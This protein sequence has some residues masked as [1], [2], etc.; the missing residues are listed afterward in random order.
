MNNRIGIMGGSFDP[1]HIGHLVTAQEALERLDL[2]TVVFLVAGGVHPTK[3]KLAAS[4]AARLEMTRLATASNSRFQVCDWEIRRGK[5][6][7]TIDALR[8]L[9]AT[10]EPDTEF[11][12][13]T[14]ADAVFEILEWKD[15]EEVASLATFIGATRPGYD[16]EH[17]KQ[18]HAA[19]LQ[20]F[21]VRYLEVPALA[22]SST[23]IR[24]RVRT[25]H[26]IRYLTG[27]EVARYIYEHQLYRKSGR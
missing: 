12:F 13:I 17:A 21:D 22:V 7:Y 25:G 19:A 10:C 23:D 18:A 20:Q 26:S 8:H 24:A 1:I 4:P 27:D 3:D 9:R 16:I 15:S 2:S 11:F 14:G 6:T 5:V